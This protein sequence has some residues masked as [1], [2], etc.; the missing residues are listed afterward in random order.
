MVAAVTADERL[1]SALRS[2]DRAV[3]Q[4][5]TPRVRQSKLA[6]AAA[7]AEA[8]LSIAPAEM[9]PAMEEV[10][11]LVID[12]RSGMLPFADWRMPLAGL[13]GAAMETAGV[14]PDE[15]DEDAIW[16]LMMA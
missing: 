14:E 7:A 10:H 1:D 11:R 13:I 4:A 3:R 2:L 15:D 12:I 6:M 8:V 5:R 16:L 9:R